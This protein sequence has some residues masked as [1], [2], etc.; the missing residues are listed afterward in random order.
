MFLQD[1]LGQN[2]SYCDHSNDKDKR[3]AKFQKLALEKAPSAEK[4]LMLCNCASG[5][6]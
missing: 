4:I 3:W 5:T 6:T 1:S 2:C